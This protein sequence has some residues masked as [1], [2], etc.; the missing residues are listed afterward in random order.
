MVA[1]HDRNGELKLLTSILRDLRE[2][3]AVESRL[4]E[5]EAALRVLNSQLEDRAAVCAALAH[6][7]GSPMST[8]D[9]DARKVLEEYG[10]RL[11]EGART[12]IQEL[13]GAAV[14][15]RSLIDALLLHSH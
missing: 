1:H 12:L 6:D 15:M 9:E 7:L 5:S 11:P 14:R 3:K 8:I 10:A 4:R 13:S 2:Q